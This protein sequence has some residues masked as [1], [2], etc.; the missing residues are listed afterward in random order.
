MSREYSVWELLRNWK[1]GQE[2]SERK[3]V[4][5]LTVKD[6]KNINKD[7]S[8]LRSKIARLEGEATNTSPNISGMPVAN[9]TSDKVGDAVTQIVDTQ[10]QIQNLE[11]LRNSALNRLSRDVMEENCIF[12]RFSLN[13]S[14]TRIAMECGGNNTA[15]SV[16]KMCDRYKW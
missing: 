11:I 10:K 6:I 3:R 9:S 7:I 2:L 4:D 13:Y 5:I 8:K 12:M 15:D 1:R 16:R 14:W